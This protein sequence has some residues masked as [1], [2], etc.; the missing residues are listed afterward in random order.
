MFMKNKWIVYVLLV[1]VFVFGLFV[2]IYKFTESP[3]SLNWDEASVA[4]N[5]YTIWHWG[6]DEWGKTLPIVFKAFGEYKMPVHVYLT[7]PFVGIF[8][9]SDFSAR[10]PHAL[11]SAF[12]ILAI[13]FLAR[14]M[15]RS[16][17]VGIF[18][19]LFLAFSPYH[20]FFSRALWE[21][22][23]ALFF[24]I[25]GLWLFYKGI[26]NAK[27]FPFAFISLGLSLY[28]YNA[29]KVFMPLII[30][31]LVAIYWREIVKVKKYFFL[32]LVA[33]LLFVL[34][35]IVQPN[36]TGLTRYDQTK[37]S[38]QQLES[39]YLYSH[40]KSKIFATLEVA[41]SH[42]PQYFSYN[43]LFVKGDQ[44][45]RNS[46]KIFGEFYKTDLIFFL[47]GVFYLLV[48]FSKR[49]LL[50]FTWVLL[51]P[52][53]GAITSLTANASRAIYM[54]GVTQI[55][56]AAGAYC[57]I[58]LISFFPVKLRLSKLD[59]DWHIVV[60]CI[61]VG[62]TLFVTAVQFVPFW[63]YLINVYPKT[64]A[65]EWQY[66]M[67]QI[68]DYVKENPD[69]TKIYM[70]NVRG[71][72][73]IFFLYYLGVSPLELAKTVKYDQTPQNTH[74]V[75]ESFGKYE[76]GEWGW[77]DSPPIYGYLYALEPYKHSG[78]RNLKDFETVKLIKYPNGSD[79][80]YLI[81]GY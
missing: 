30:I 20:I 25:F 34:G 3:P 58:K 78:L 35:F 50:L 46:V 66:G 26:D 38:D 10:L 17:S 1:L 72:P 4:Y 77:V 79:A 55:I 64:D 9:P 57:L 80:F 32:S 70:D 75:V 67:E 42:Y 22:G 48:K 41:I 7:A 56:E 21:L 53:P 37:L 44:N 68:V 5:A 2:R 39:T 36:L 69:Y 47:F 18:A 27:F 61:V 29:S 19:A 73:Y 71:Q 23:F 11:I 16:D 12:T 31:A 59:N 43:Y 8:G 40:T 6:K 49:T 54:L 62:L 60:G 65:T 15:F 24:I 45:P 28:S 13:F 74:N 63:N 51:S 33:L 81:S 76:F 52:L 14:K